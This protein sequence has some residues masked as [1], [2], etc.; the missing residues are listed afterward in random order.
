MRRPDRCIRLASAGVGPGTAPAYSGVADAPGVGW[1]SAT[2]G[3]AGGT[4]REALPAVWGTVQGLGELHANLIV[5]DAS[6]VAPESSV[7][8]WATISAPVLALRL[9]GPVED[10]VRERVDERGMVKRK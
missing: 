2:F 7:A 1:G 4:F 10:R 9:V 3:V 6:S 5:S 8:T